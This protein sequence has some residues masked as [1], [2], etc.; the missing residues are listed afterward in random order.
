VVE[1]DLKSAELIRV[2]LEAKGFE[3]LHALS[4]EEALVLALERPLLSL[5][6]LDLL[7]PAMDGWE[8]LRRIKEMPALSGIP[9]VLISI[10]ADN[11]RGAS[12]GAAA[13]I[14][15][16]MSR[17]ELDDVLARL[18]LSAPSARVDVDGDPKAAA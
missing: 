14:Q 2:Q 13:V 10:L 16:P 15:K 4:G 5:I 3:V 18:N 7:L 11:S 17:Q 9:V 1:G 12:M 6:T 8:L